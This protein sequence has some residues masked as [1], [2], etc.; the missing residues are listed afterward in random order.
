M[1]EKEEVMKKIFFIAILFIQLFTVRLSTAHNMSCSNDDT[2]IDT[3]LSSGDFLEEELTT[4]SGSA[5]TMI[6]VLVVYTRSAR[7]SLDE[8]DSLLPSE[9]RAKLREILEAEEE[10]INEVLV[11]SDLRNREVNIVGMEEIGVAT[12]NAEQQTY[13]ENACMEE[14]LLKL[15]GNPENEPLDENGDSNVEVETENITLDRVHQLRE[16]YGADFV[17]LLVTNKDTSNTNCGFTIPYNLSHEELITTKCSEKAVA[18][19]EALNENCPQSNQECRCDADDVEI[20][21]ACDTNECRECVS[22][23]HKAYWSAK[24]AFSV[25]AIEQACRDQYAF[26]HEIGHSM[27]IFHDR[28]SSTTEQTLSLADGSLNFPYKRYG[29]GYDN[30]EAMSATYDR[31]WRTVVTPESPK[32]CKTQSFINGKI[33]VEPN[34]SNPDIYIS[35]TIGQAPHDTEVEEPAG[36]VYDNEQWDEWSNFDRIAANGPAHAARAI[37]ETWDFLA[38]L[39]HSSTSCESMIFRRL[40]RSMSVSAASRQMDIVLSSFPELCKNEDEYIL[41]T[42]SDFITVSQAQN[43]GTNRK[44]V[45]VE[46]EQNET[47][48]IRKGELRYRYSL[49]ISRPS[50]SIV[51]TQAVSPIKS[52]VCKVAPMG[53]SLSSITDLN[54]SNKSITGIESFDLNGLDQLQSLNLSQNSIYSIGDIFTDLGNLVELDLSENRVRSLGRYAFRDLSSLEQLDL[55]GNQVN[56]IDRYAFTSLNNLK[57][58]D[59]S[60]NELQYIGPSV[61]EDLTSLERLDLSENEIIAILNNTFKYATQLKYLWLNHNEIDSLSSRDFENLSRLRALALD[62]NEIESL[63][64]TVFSDLSSLR[65]LW[66]NSN[67]LETLPSGVFDGLSRLRY[68]NLSYNSL[69]TALPDEVCTFIKGVRRLV[70]KG[71]DI[72]VICPPVTESSSSASTSSG[73]GLMDTMKG[74]LDFS[75]FTNNNEHNV[76]DP[77][78]SISED[79]FFFLSEQDD[80]KKIIQKMYEDGIGPSEISDIIGV[81]THK[82][83][84]IISN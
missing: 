46:I 73:R 30:L 16:Q 57:T 78:V 80:D 1:I 19:C 12:I 84:R 68:L 43:T 21:E 8:N 24:N 62:N 60:Q 18:D 26:V 25:S 48:Y 74:L 15:I 6:D 64:S 34:F 39:V 69:T 20:A 5:D 83:S 27:G 13:A 3:L 75:V 79:D 38:S 81:S 14:N 54:L 67:A 29:F 33:E 2:Q 82:V 35:S 7:S 47:C 45:S 56:S 55:R 22:A 49:G 42:P 70:I 44:T 9:E 72:N 40:N 36:K 53:G 37:D 23:T 11:N 63:S 59:L 41:S 71:I 28:G 76:N 17:H 65:Y 77:S 52:E 50:T 31:C 4:V 51:I 32:H 61:F 10:K 66:L 58:L